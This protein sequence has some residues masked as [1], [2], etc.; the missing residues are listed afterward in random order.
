MLLTLQKIALLLPLCAL[1]LWLAGCGE[2][3][4]LQST[5]TVF[6][7]RQ[8]SPARIELEVFPALMPADGISTAQVL[9][10]V[11]ND[12]GSLSG[13]DVAVSFGLT[14]RLG[15]VTQNGN[16]NQSGV[17]PA[18]YTAGTVPGTTT[19]VARAGNA[20]ATVNITLVEQVSRNFSASVVQSAGSTNSLDVAVTVPGVPPQQTGGV[21]VSVQAIDQDGVALPATYYPTG[22]AGV[23]DL[24]GNF[25]SRIFLGPLTTAQIQNG[26]QG[27][28]VVTV[29]SR[30]LTLI[31]FS[32]AGGGGGSGSGPRAPTFPDSVVFTPSQISFGVRDNS[33]IS[34]P[35]RAQFP[36]NA[37]GFAAVFTLNPGFGTAAA[38]G[39]TGFFT[40]STPGG[41]TGPTQS[42]V[43]SADGTASTT[44]VL[45]NVRSSQIGSGLVL[46][47]N[48]RV[49]ATI[50]GVPFQFAGSAPVTLLPNTQPLSLLALTAT[51]TRLS[52]SAGASFS[53]TMTARVQAQDGSFPAGVFVTFGSDQSRGVIFPTT[54]ATDASGVARATFSIDQV[55][56]SLLANGLF[57]TLRAS[58]PSGSGTNLQ[59]TT[60]VFVSPSFGPPDHLVLSSNVRPN[61]TT[62][63]IFVQGSSFPTVTQ[64]TYDVL[65]INDNVARSATERVQFV[66]E[67]GGLKGGESLEPGAGTSLTT[68][69]LILNGRATTTLRSGIRAGT[70]RIIA[71][72]DNVISNGQPDP[73][74]PRS[75][76]ITISISGGLPSG[77]NLSIV[78][79]VLNISGLIRADLTDLLTA[80]LAD[81]FNN[82]VIAGT[83][84]SF[85]SYDR[86]TLDSAASVTANGVV[87]STSSRATGV[88]VSQLP[89]PVSGFVGVQ[90]QTNAGVDA[91]A[92]TIAQ[93]PARTNQLY[94]GTDGGGVYQGVFNPSGFLPFGNLAWQNVGTGR[95]GLEN[96]Y[97]RALAID[98]RT[99]LNGILYAGTERGLF[100]STGSGGV[101]LARS[102]SGR[103]ENEIPTPGF[104]T[105]PATPTTF[106]LTRASTMSRARTI[107]R[108]NG[109]RRFDF[110]Y[111]SP[112]QI[113]FIQTRGE[114][115]P[116]AANLRVS[117]DFDQALPDRVPVTSIVVSRNTFQN[118]TPNEDNAIVYAG[119]LGGGVFRSTDGGTTWVAINTGL[120]NLN[121]LTLV[122]ARMPSRTQDIVLLAGTQGGGVF[123]LTGGN[124]A[125][126]GQFRVLDEALV[127]DAQAGTSLRWDSA[128]LNLTATHI[129]SM[130]SDP[131]RPIDNGLPFRVYV[132]TDVGGVFRTLTNNLFTA[133][134]AALSW[135]PA[136][137]NVSAANLSNTRVTG[138]AVD[139]Q[140][141]AV[142]A[143]TLDDADPKNPIGGMFRST[144]NGS[145]FFP[146][147]SP[148]SG[149]AQPLQNSRL[150]SVSIAGGLLF[151]GGDGRQMWLS[152][153]PL[154]AVTASV[155]FTEVGR[156]G[157]LASA[158]ITVNPQIDNNI[159][160]TTRV[161]FSGSPQVVIT[162]LSGNF[163]IGAAGAQ[164]FLVTISDANGN[165]LPGST[166]VTIT[167]SPKGTPSRTTI[168][169]PDTLEG[170]TDFAFNVVNDLAA[171]T[172]TSG[173]ATGATGITISVKATIN[174]PSGGTSTAEDSIARQL[175]PPVTGP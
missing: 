87:T 45:T 81:Q 41:A 158:T 152:R 132:G 76:P 149:S 55:P 139:P 126:G 138:L 114:P 161:L 47:A 73:G 67:N 94:V 8:K 175:V 57:L 38:G 56:A 146:I 171:V 119:T 28:V 91:T 42:V 162:P 77:Q 78:P 33:T 145:L 26:V 40:P 35:L 25:T 173:T 93:D 128:N 19:I 23:T 121:V 165:P 9:A 36:Q 142:F 37:R 131:D 154:D 127:T 32:I 159:Y 82:P 44:L 115:A 27:F 95:T 13:P 120:K 79:G 84:V 50:N 105:P 39:I 143:S 22:G 20:S 169:I 52:V 97:V 135:S 63:T 53:V 108:E 69:A 167:S 166:T 1:S 118:A 12:E 48:T 88:L 148:L 18:I 168:S 90:A 150:R 106:T 14:S 10:R 30:N 103:V 144:D 163:T 96:G 86:V 98:P 112:T 141:L 104:S 99:G 59:A 29:N 75:E 102:G 71:F 74:E 2:G 31:P 60:S 54:Q 92:L 124:P 3:A 83:R 58:A 70:V 17:A 49:D 130:A 85:R 6:T 65:D 46:A 156:I 125:L 140:S 34:I 147:G 62:S 61:P 137:R 113:R 153:N 155:Q 111:D 122:H 117:Y 160:D 21:A 164:D 43:V 109:V 7:V 15:T 157:S 100:R 4:G 72:I 89:S 116:V 11:Y 66:L 107:I 110:V 16:V 129:L 172:A 68:G 136:T 151:V 101:W 5:D 51:P 64:I 174:L 134:P 123:K 170:G 133:L 24:A 80:Y